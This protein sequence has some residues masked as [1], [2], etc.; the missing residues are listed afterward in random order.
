MEKRNIVENGRLTMPVFMIVCVKFKNLKVSQP[1]SL[2]TYFC[3]SVV[4][5]IQCLRIVF[6]KTFM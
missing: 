6:N 3:F 2:L 4:C 1:V 5:S